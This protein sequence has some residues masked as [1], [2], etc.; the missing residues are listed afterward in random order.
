MWFSKQSV[1]PLSESSGGS[2]DDTDDANSSSNVTGYC[3]CERGE[4][5][6]YMIGCNNKDCPI[7]WFHYSCLKITAKM[8]QK[9]NTSVLNAMCRKPRRQEQKRNEYT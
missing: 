5:Y 4:D 2:R 9:E 6:D 3:Y 8:Y 7:E 1:M